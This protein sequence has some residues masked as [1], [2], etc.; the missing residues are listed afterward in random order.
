M[1]NEALLVFGDEELGISYRVADVESVLVSE[2]K[3]VEGGADCIPLSICEVRG[4]GF[5]V[6]LKRDSFLRLDSKVVDQN[7]SEGDI[8]GEVYVSGIKEWASRRERIVEQDSV[9]APSVR[10][11][12]FVLEEPLDAREILIFKMSF[13]EHQFVGQRLV[14]TL[15]CYGLSVYC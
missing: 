11:S 9:E 1:I 14:N 10:K 4:K 13:R 12:T 15:R 6:D 7:V 3:N 8:L 2:K 5:P